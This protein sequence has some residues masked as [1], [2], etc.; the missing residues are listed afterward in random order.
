M[1]FSKATAGASRVRIG[2][3]LLSL[4]TVAL[5]ALAS[6][7]SLELKPENTAVQYTVTGPLHTVHGTF[8]LKRGRI[9]FDT[10]TGRASG[11]VVVDV[12]SGNSGSDARDSR[13]HANV[14][15]SKKYPDAVFAPDRIVGKLSVPGASGVKV[16]GTFTIHGAAH[17]MTIEVQTSG[18]EEQFRAAMSFDIPYV[19][20]G[21]KDP[22]NFLLK[23]SKT[24]QMTIEAAGV[25]EKR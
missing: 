9:D 15:E 22:S 11:Q 14:L 19:A 21:M 24:V 10:D 16:H 18:T 23:V 12:T 20:W 7:Y 6:H 1:D 4:A 17:E 13:M 2:K 5:P 8:S 25:L 3:A